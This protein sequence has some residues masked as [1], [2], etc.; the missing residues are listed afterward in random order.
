MTTPKPDELGLLAV[1]SGQVLLIRAHGE[2]DWRIPRA[3]VADG[4]VDATHLALVRAH[5]LTVVEVIDAGVHKV[6]HHQYALH[7]VKITE[8]PE[9]EGLETRLVRLSQL[10]RALAEPDKH[11]LDALL[12]Y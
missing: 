8:R 5:G 12:H 9:I 7:R 2:T 6:G 4:D 3:V 10:P 1:N 11:L